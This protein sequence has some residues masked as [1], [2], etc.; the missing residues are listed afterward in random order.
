MILVEKAKQ[1]T[2]SLQWQRQ[3]IRQMC[4]CIGLDCVDQINRHVMSVREPKMK[5]QVIKDKDED[6]GEGFWST[7]RDLEE[8]EETFHKQIVSSEDQEDIKVDPKIEIKLYKKRYLQ[9]QNMQ[10][11]YKQACLMCTH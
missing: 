2:Q 9:M 11:N 4:P 5:L 6:W 1:E 7:S 10:L 3:K 8:I